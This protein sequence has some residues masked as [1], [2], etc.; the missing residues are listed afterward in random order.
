ME[1]EGG[2]RNDPGH[3]VLAEIRTKGT[4]L[5]WKHKEWSANV[6]KQQPVSIGNGEIAPWGIYHYY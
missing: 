3:L 1:D 6:C 2:Q 5:K 4:K